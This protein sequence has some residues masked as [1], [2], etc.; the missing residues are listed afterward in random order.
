M[1]NRFYYGVSKCFVQN[2]DDKDIWVGIKKIVEFYGGPEETVTYYEGSSIRNSSI[3][4]NFE[5][6]VES[7]SFPPLVLDSDFSMTYRNYTNVDLDEY[8]IH[9]V[10][11]VRGYLDSVSKVTHEENTD[12]FD[13][14]IRLFSVPVSDV[15]IGSRPSYHYYIK[16]KELSSELLEHLESILQGDDENDP[17]IPDLNELEDFLEG[18]ADL[19][20]TDHGDGTWTAFTEL[21]HVIE[22][23]GPTEFKIVWDKVKYLDEDTFKIKSGH[24][25]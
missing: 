24:R 19:R 1:N 16:S 12:P 23:I 2:E 21:P 5:M 7:F 6:E 22:T 18:D 8:E 13:F 11:N 3:L 10:Y 15:V 20:I 4:N 17:R 9:F 14:S 25:S